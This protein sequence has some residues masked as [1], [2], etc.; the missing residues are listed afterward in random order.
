LDAQYTDALDALGHYQ[1]LW[2]VLGAR[3]LDFRY[4]VEIDLYYHCLFPNY[5]TTDCNHSYVSSTSHTLKS[6]SCHFEEGVTMTWYK[7]CT[8]SLALLLPLVFTYFFIEEIV[9]LFPP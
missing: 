5:S 2:S 6:L 3:F 9:D 7:F 4:S 1:G 8:E